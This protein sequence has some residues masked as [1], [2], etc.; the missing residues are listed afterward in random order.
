VHTS[1]ST[2]G[3]MHVATVAGQGVAQVYGGVQV[4]ARARVAARL[5]PPTQ[6]ISRAGRATS[7]VGWRV[8]RHQPVTRRRYVW[9]LVART[10]VEGE[11]ESEKESQEAV[12]GE[13]RR[14][15]SRLSVK[16]VDGNCQHTSMSVFGASASAKTLAFADS[17][18]SALR[19][20][21]RVT[22]MVE[23]RT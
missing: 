14:E 16:I 2:L 13:Q 23:R 17:I 18:R 9:L 3:D 8:L 12:S 5:P 6:A 21:S 1:K 11:S 22:W 10:A 19:L 4:G 7:A 20:S 15:E